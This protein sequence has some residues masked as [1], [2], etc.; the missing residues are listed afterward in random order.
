MKNTTEN[1][2]VIM[3][4]VDEEV[5]ALDIKVTDRQVISDVEEWNEINLS[6]DN[7]KQMNPTLWKVGFNFIRNN[8]IT[9]TNYLNMKNWIPIYSPIY[10]AYEMIYNDKCISEFTD[11]VFL[12]GAFHGFTAGIIWYL[13]G[14]G[15]F[16]LLKKYNT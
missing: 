14:I 2:E 15:F 6:I 13:L 1:K 4:F 11:Y 9:H 10:F 16:S 5:I 8:K 12:N 3:T 7:L